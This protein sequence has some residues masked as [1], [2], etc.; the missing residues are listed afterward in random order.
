M[1]PMGNNITKMNTT[2]ENMTNL[3]DKTIMCQDNKL[4]PIAARRGKLISETKYRDIGKSFSM[5]H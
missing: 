5:I 4:H 1:N 2:S 3:V